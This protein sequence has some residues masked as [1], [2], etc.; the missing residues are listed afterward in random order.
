MM[1]YRFSTA[2]QPYVPASPPTLSPR[3]ESSASGFGRSLRGR[4]L[5]AEEAELEFMMDMNILG[6]GKLEKIETYLC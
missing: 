2:R 4:R 5:A 6:F 1:L 3:S